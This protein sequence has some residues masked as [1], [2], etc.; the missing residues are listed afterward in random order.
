MFE[1]SPNAV[2]SVADNAG[3]K[4]TNLAVNKIVFLLMLGT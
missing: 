3:L 4:L 2:L 1:E